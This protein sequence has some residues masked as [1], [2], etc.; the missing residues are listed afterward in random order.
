MS[1]TQ[2]FGITTPADMLGKATRELVRFEADPSADNAF[3][4]F[5]SICHVRDYSRAAGLD[6]SALDSDTDFQLCRLAA[7]SGKHLILDKRSAPDAAARGFD[8]HGD[9][10]YSGDEEFAVLADGQRI[11][12]LSLGRRVLASVG[13]WLR[14]QSGPSAPAI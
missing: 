6:V 14:P 13:A 11:P 5:V 1:S 7:N 10:S 3:N 8:T 4:F 2:V 9:V 12:V